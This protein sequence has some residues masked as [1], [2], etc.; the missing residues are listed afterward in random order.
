MESMVGPIVLPEPLVG[1]YTIKQEKMVS[2]PT[3]T[4]TYNRTKKPMVAVIKKADEYTSRDSVNLS[5]DTI[6]VAPRA[7]IVKKE[8]NP[9]P[10]RRT[11]APH[12]VTEVDS[13]PRKSVCASDDTFWAQAGNDTSDLDHEAAIM[14]RI[15]YAVGERPPKPGRAG[16][17]PFLLFT[18][19]K[20]EECKTYCSATTSAP[21]G[22][23]AIRRTL[24]VWWKAASDEEKEPFVNQSRWAQTQ[25]NLARSRWEREVGYWDDEAYT[26]RANYIRE[27]G[28]KDQGQA[29]GGAAAAIGVSKRQTNTSNCVVLDH[30]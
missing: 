19:A 11:S 26:V 1:P 15:L 17:N 7:P 21:A 22:R 24:G 5:D 30:A 27:H 4:P 2:I 25:A 9:E 6:A 8:S 29:T 23:D 12:W 28:P 10:V 16:V 13:K 14:S 3:P 20:W 18:K